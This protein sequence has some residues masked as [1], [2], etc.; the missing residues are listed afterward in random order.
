MYRMS[1]TDEGD[2]GH[3]T[4]CNDHDDEDMHDHN[5]DANDEADGSWLKYFR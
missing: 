3:R 5:D 4:K 1:N 2:D